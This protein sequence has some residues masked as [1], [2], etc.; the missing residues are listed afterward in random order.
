MKISLA[1]MSLFLSGPLFAQDICEIIS[2]ASIVAGDGTFLGRIESEHKSKSILNGY[3]SFGSEY[4]AT[5]IWNENGKYGSQYSRL[6]AF[7]E[8][9]SD[10][11][12]IIK[13]GEVI[14]YLTL[15]KSKRGSLNPFVTKTCDYY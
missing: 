7:N 11:P 15:N 6:S 3:G 12:M 5:S 2:G 1:A 8:M 14:G 9:A 13:D 4:S 10:P